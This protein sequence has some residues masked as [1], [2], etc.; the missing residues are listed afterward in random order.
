LTDKYGEFPPE[1]N[2]HI[3]PGDQTE[4]K[5]NSQKIKK[6]CSIYLGIFAV[7]LVLAAIMTK[8]N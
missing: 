5:L 8:C 7:M 2:K 6:G 1:Q 4:Q 3:N